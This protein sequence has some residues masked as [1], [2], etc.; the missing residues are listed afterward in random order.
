MTWKLLENKNK[1]L[2]RDIDIWFREKFVG[3]GSQFLSWY[4]SSVESQNA[5]VLKYLRYYYEYY[6]KDDSGQMQQQYKRAFNNN[7]HLKFTFKN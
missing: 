6:E 5:N 3:R 7:L 2:V 4:M 1:F